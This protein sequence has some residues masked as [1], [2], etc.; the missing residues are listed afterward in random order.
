MGY[1]RRIRCYRQKS[2][3]F[4][5]VCEAFAEESPYPTLDKVYEYVYSEPNYPFIDKLEN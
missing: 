3:D 4:V 1:R 2:R 5:D